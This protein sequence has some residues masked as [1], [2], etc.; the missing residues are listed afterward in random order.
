MPHWGFE[1]VLSVVVSKSWPATEV[2]ADRNEGFLKVVRKG[3]VTELTELLD[4]DETLLA[5]RSPDEGYSAMHYAAM[6]VVK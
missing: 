6:F 1:F 5:S 3:D 4:K 2:M